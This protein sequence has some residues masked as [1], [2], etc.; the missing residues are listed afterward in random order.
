MT[1]E[2]GLLFAVINIPVSVL[3]MFLIL[4]FYEATDKQN[5]KDKNNKM[6]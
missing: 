2:H 1:L 4:R 6:Y 5:A 3:V